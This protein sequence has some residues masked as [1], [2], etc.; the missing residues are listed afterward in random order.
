MR[1]HPFRRF[2]L[3]GITSGALSVAALPPSKAEANPGSAEA[4]ETK[5]WLGVQMERQN[6]SGLPGVSIQRAVPGSPAEQA[7]LGRGDIVQKV[8]GE[9]V[10]TP[11][12]LSNLIGNKRAGETIVLDIAG[13]RARQVSLTLAA[14]PTN[15]GDL[16]ARLVGRASPETQAVNA[17]SGRLEDVTPQDGKVRIVELWAT[18]CGPCKLIQPL[19]TRQV[20]A[21]DDAH[22]EFVGVAEDEAAAVRRYLERYPTNYRVLIDTENAVG[23]AYWA[24]ATPTFVLV[25]TDG[26]VVAHQSGIDNVSALFDRARTLV[27]AI[28][29]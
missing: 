6:L 3:I 8:N 17:K 18:W 28:N 20:D 4:S 16:S 29:E 12:E 9:D 21:M 26:K 11:A 22:F 1:R 5:A 23:D 25:D 27:K 19:I 14:P 2:A 15:L 10:R 7:S 24:T 13:K